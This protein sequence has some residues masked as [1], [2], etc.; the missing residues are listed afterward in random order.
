MDNKNKVIIILI[1]VIILLVSVLAFKIINQNNNSNNSIINTTSTIDENDSIENNSDDNIMTSI[2]AKKQINIG[3]LIFLVLDVIVITAVVPKLLENL[4]FKSSLII[5]VAY[6]I[7]MMIIF[8]NLLSAG[9]VAW[10][11]IALMLLFYYTILLWIIN[12]FLLG[13]NVIA[14]FFIANILNI[15]IYYASIFAMV[16]LLM[17]MVSIIL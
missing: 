8:N 7:I 16:F 9:V 2:N 14:Y 15:G 5:M 3:S 4:G 1:C 6:K 12:K 10:L 11:A 13:I 17:R